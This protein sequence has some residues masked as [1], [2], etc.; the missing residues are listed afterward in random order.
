MAAQLI[1]GKAGSQRIGRA[2]GRYR[3]APESREEMMRNKYFLSLVLACLLAA[4]PASWAWRTREPLEAFDL[5]SLKVLWIGETRGG[6]RALVLAPDGRGR[7][8]RLGDYL[9]RDFGM[10]VKFEPQRLHLVEV[11]MVRTGDGDDWQ[12]RRVTLERVDWP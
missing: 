9:G 2:A 1:E 11:V 8:V 6:L 7:L 10:L 3:P 4:S 5:S 12:E